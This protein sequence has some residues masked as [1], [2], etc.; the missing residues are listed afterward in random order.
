MVY[1]GIVQQCCS[2]RFSRC[3]QSLNSLIPANIRRFVSFG[4]QSKTLKCPLLAFLVWLPSQCLF[5]KDIWHPCMCVC[6]CAHLCVFMSYILL[7]LSPSSSP[8][9]K[10]LS[11]L[12]KWPFSLLCSELVFIIRIYFTSYHFSTSSLEVRFLL[13]CPLLMHVSKLQLITTAFKTRRGQAGYE[14]N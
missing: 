12:E 3:S 14:R 5:D 2:W 11:L 10:G 4:F 1:W 7:L 6:P 9:S 8:L 13:C